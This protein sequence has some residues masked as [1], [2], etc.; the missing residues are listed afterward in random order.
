MGA[1][2]TAVIGVLALMGLAFTAGATI[3]PTFS[4]PQTL[5]WGGTHVINVGQNGVIPNVGDW[6]HDGLKDLMVGTYTGGHIYYYQNSGTN[7]NPV[8]D[9]QVMLTADGNPITMTFG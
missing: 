2:R 3:I 5:Y 4:P 1:E 9:T 7:A 8:F 6:N